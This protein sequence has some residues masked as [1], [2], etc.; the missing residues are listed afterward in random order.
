MRLEPGP[1]HCALRDA[2]REFA[3]SIVKEHAA[4]VDRDHRFP[5]EAVAAAAQLDLMG[6]L[7]P[8][9]YGGAGLDHLGFTICV[10]ELAQACASTAVIV[11][12]H[13]SVA[14]EPIVLFG[15]EEQKRS[16][17]PRLASG[18]VLGAFA[19]TEPAAGS[20]AAS[21]ETVARR[22][23]AEWVLSGR[24]VFI[25]NVGLAGMYLVFARTGP[26]DRAAGISAFIVPADTEGVQVG[27]VFDKM[28]LHG[29]ATGELVLEEARVPY[30]NLLDAEGGGFRIAM[31]AL[32]SG[33]IGIS[34]QAMGIA[35]AAVAEA[36]G[37]AREREQFGRPVGTFE[38]VAFML[39]DMATT[40]L[41]GRQMAY[42]AAA[43][44]SAGKP[45]TREAAMAKLFCT[46][47]AMTIATD[48]LQV[49]GGDGYVVDNPFERHFRDAKALQI[50][51]GTNQVQRVVI[52][53]RL[54]A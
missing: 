7:V 52:A 30:A 18:E 29:S 11:D 48:A 54:L 22:H 45:F 35:A 21:L 5:S 15:S 44:C 42:N 41:A 39:A 3:Q 8:S 37:H 19:L 12:V 31:R 13:N 32:D 53:R 17:L 38:G 20:D 10:E 4:E 36:T 9:R 26:G 50:Y 27:Q 28:G 16:W 14:T 24:K 33:R 40:L 43:L 46:D 1:D 49:A 51:E 2:V 47:G 25:T 34:G 23:G 6:M